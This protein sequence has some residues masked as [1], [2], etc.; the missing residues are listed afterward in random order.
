[1]FIWLT[2]PEGIS[3]LEVFEK[4]LARGV[5]VLPG[6]P[7]YTDG[8]GGNTIRLNFSNSTEEKIKTGMERFAAVLLRSLNVRELALQEGLLFPC[9][10]KRTEQSPHNLTPYLAPD[11]MGSTR[12]S[13]SYDIPCT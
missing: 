13:R 1:M 8:G 10:S 12:C 2:L 6:T 3:S 4:T 11:G 9:P 7:F 5:A